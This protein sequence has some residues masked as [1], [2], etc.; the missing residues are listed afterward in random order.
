MYYVGLSKSIQTVYPEIKV[1]VTE[2]GGS[3]DAT[4]RLRQ[5]LIDGATSN[6]DQVLDS[7][8]GTRAFK[9]KPFTEMRVLWW[10]DIL[11]LQWIVA[12]SSGV[13]FMHDLGGKEYN[14]GG[15]GGAVVP[16]TQDIL[17][18]LNVK[19]KYYLAGQQDA[20]EAMGNRRIMG[21]AKLGPVPDAFVQQ[22]AASLPINLIGL[23]EEEQNNVLKA[24]PYFIPVTIPA[25]AY[26]GT[27][28]TRT[29]GLPI[30][31]IV[32]SSLSQEMGYKM[33]K[34]MQEGGKQHW[35]AAYPTS[36]NTDIPALTFTSKEFIHAGAVQ[37]LKEKGYAV[38]KH[39]IPP[40]YKP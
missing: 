40:E 29:V 6:S 18:F 30:G 8:Q 3:V 38:P 36:A 7:R 27:A 37:Y 17:N 13:E 12:K 20:I 5:G 22:V 1:T 39:L 32:T 16:N 34:A 9:D 11:K 31:V 21:T 25:G 19:P 10:Y 2:T 28:L 4:R 35:Q 15:Q 33:W 14:P 24:Y 26:A 23:T